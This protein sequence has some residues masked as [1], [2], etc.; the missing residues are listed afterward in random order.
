MSPK[1]LKIVS[2]NI[3]KSQIELESEHRGKP[4][5]TKQVDQR[6]KRD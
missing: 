1:A 4:I 6:L 2:K 3:R 5:N